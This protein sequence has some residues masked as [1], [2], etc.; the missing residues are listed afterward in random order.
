[1]IWLYGDDWQEQANAQAY[2]LA[3]DRIRKR[4]INK[5]RFL[6][7]TLFFVPINGL[8]AL[9]ALS[10]NS[11]E[12]YFFGF[13]ILIWLGVFIAHLISA[14]PRQRWLVRREMNYGESLQVE[15]SRLQTPSPQQKEKLKRGKYY[16]VGDDG[17]LVEVEDEV[18]RLED[19]PKREMDK[20]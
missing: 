18:L 11:P 8:L 13:I 20:S 17:E 5:W 2:A 7:H 3:Q 14:F 16:E 4:R 9:S 12:N 6:G 1:M 19:K 10:G 15:L